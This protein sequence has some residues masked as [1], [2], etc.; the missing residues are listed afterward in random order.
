MINQRS[1]KGLKH[2]NLILIVALLPLG[3]YSQKIEVLDGIEGYPIR[4]VID[5]NELYYSLSDKGEIHKIDVSNNSPTPVLVATGLTEPASMVIRFPFLYVAQFGPGKISKIDLR[6][7]STEAEDVLTGLNEPNGLVMWN[8]TM[9]FSDSR[10]SSVSKFDITNSSPGPILVASN[11]NFPTTLAI[12]GRELFITESL[13]NAVSKI[14][15]TGYSPMATKVIEGLNRPLGTAFD[16][17][18]LYVTELIGDQVLKFD[19]TEAPVNAVDIGISFDGPSDVLVADNGYIY[20]LET[21][22]AIGTISKIKRNTVG[23]DSWRTPI[24]SLGPNPANEFIQL[25]NLDQKATY[26]IYTT[27]GRQVC[28]GTVFPH[29]RVKI[30]FLSSGIYTIQIE[31]KGSFQF[32][33]N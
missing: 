20:F 22:F 26:V 10:T 31:D 28:K 30:H 6:S 24:Y 27:N 15:L 18:T 17:D 2:F 21:S 9:Y 5:G 12:R 23:T 11:L 25:N 14:P 7:T 4:M 13:G 29:D 32:V 33:K 3:V 16:L 8:D 1:L 19:I